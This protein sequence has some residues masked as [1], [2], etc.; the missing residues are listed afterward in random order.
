MF[1]IG[2]PEI[3]IIFIIV[4]IFVNPKE[5]PGLFRKLGRGVQQIR[6]MREDFTQSLRDVQEDLGLTNPGTRGA[7]GS[8]DGVR[9]ARDPGDAKRRPEWW[10]EGGGI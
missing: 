2:L 5:L 4:V 3:L 1:N 8:T 10:N 9:S 6:R 7:Y